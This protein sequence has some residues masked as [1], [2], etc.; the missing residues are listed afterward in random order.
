MQQASF[1]ESHPHLKD[2]MKFLDALNEE[3]DRGAALIALAMIDDL[4]EQA[5]LAFLIDDRE[6]KRLLE[7]FNAPLGTFSTRT[8]A[9]Y[10]LGLISEREF[11]ECNKLR[12]VRNE[13]AHNVHQTFDDE[14]VKEI[15]ATLNFSIK[16]EPDNK[17]PPKSQYTT[18]AIC[19]ILNLTNRPHYVAKKRIVFEPWPY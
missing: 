8:L 14:R 2:F 10:S 6:S 13:F 12:K 17:L 7:G 11:N 15:C 5:I 4:L 9:A 3:S 19:L 18:A 16:D 1:E